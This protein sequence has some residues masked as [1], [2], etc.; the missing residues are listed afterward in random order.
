VHDWMPKDPFEEFCGAIAPLLW[1]LIPLGI[2][3]IIALH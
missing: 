3:L 1:V 2:I